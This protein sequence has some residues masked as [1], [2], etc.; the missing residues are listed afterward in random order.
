MRSR[1]RRQQI[2]LLN[3]R[4]R[5]SHRFRQLP[6]NR[7]HSLE[8]LLLNLANQANQG[9]PNSRLWALLPRQ[10]PGLRKLKER[11]L[12]NS[13]NRNRLSRLSAFKRLN[14]QE[15]PRQNK[16]RKLSGP[17]KHSLAPYNRRQLRQFRKLNAPRKFS[18]LGKLNHALTKHSALKS[19]SAPAQASNVRHK[20]SV[21]HHSERLPKNS[22]LIRNDKSKGHR[23]N[24]SNC[25]RN[26]V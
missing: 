19:R 26:E 21:R 16:H 17:E 15:K 1:L 24:V 5:L 10:G 23:G 13:S 14:V 9:P 22:D 11:K 6:Q 12:R 4:H 25:R 3:R 18:A 20:R 7:V 2:F 8:P